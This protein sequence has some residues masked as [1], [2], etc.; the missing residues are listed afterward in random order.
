M[1]QSKTFIEK[2]IL[3]R[4]AAQLSPLTMIRIDFGRTLHLISCKLSLGQ[5]QSASHLQIKR[6]GK[7]S[8]MDIFCFKKKK[9]SNTKLMR[10]FSVPSSAICISFF[11]N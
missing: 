11:F 1:D 8:V 5:F 2:K 7:V 3:I 10:R 6:H 4:K 9:N